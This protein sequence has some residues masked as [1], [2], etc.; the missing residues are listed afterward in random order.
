MSTAPVAVRLTETPSS[1]AH[2]PVLPPHLVAIGLDHT[3]APIEL[4]ERLAFTE[5]EVP[6]ALANLT[7]PDVAPFE[8]VVI[9]STC[10]RVEVYGITRS[11]RPREE[12]M[13][14]VARYRGLDPREL[15]GAV[16]I[17]RD[18]AVAH[19]LAAT[20][21]GLQSL[22]LGEAQIQG[23]VRHALKQAVTARSAGPELRRLF[24]SAVSAGRKVRSSTAVARG[25][26]SVSQASVELVRQRVRTL[27]ES[28]VLLIGAG[29]AGELAAK[30]LVKHH[31]GELLVLGRGGA[32]A[33]RLAARYGGQALTS[34]E[35][36]DALARSD[37]VI[38]S[39]SSPY[40]V[41]QRRQL[42]NALNQAVR[43]DSRPLLLVD[44]ATPRDVD[45]AAAGLDGVELFT[46][47]DLR[48]I[49]ERTL[50][51][52]RTELPAAYSIVHA[53]VARFERWLKSRETAVVLHGHL[54]QRP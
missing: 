40:P 52:R 44:L 38:S 46:I 26:A 22:V 54:T 10:N 14:F 47:D 48:P 15:E 27:S 31:P 2:S 3:T 35:L 49:V 53:E 12:L 6:M 19:H 4:R 5:S 11:W 21:A 39:T 17:Y 34:D 1:V 37:V 25:A 28:T 33:S 29:T 36:D 23:Q 16:Y 9:L 32:R 8:Q 20:S 41:L 30:H 42:E 50:E 43:A 13:S 24:D 18:T 7:N 51:Q 45:P